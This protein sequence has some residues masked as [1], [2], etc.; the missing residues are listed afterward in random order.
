MNTL[1]TYAR[2]R[3][4]TMPPIKLGL[5]A[6]TFIGTTILSIS[7][8]GLAEV[9]TYQENYR[10][11]V[12][13]RIAISGDTIVSTVLDSAAHVFEQNPDGTWSEQARLHA[14]DSV[15]NDSFGVSVAIDRDTAIIGAYE[16][17]D[18]GPFSGSAYVFRRGADGRWAE[19]VKLRGSD[20]RENFGWSSAID[21]NTLMVLGTDSVYVFE[22][23]RNGVWTQQSRLMPSGG[24]LSLGD[25]VAISGDT[26]VIGADRDNDEGPFAGAAYIF[27]RNA[28]GDWSERSKVVASDGSA[29]D[30]FGRSVAIDGAKV[31]II[32]G[33][34]TYLFERDASGVWSELAK[35][36]SSYGALG[37]QLGETAAISGDVAAMASRFDDADGSAY[38]FDL[39]APWAFEKGSLLCPGDINGDDIAELAVLSRRTGQVEVKD[40]EG[41]WVNGFGVG[42]AVDTELL[43]DTNG[44][45][46]PEVALLLTGPTRGEVR[47]LLNGGVLGTASFR[48]QA[49]TDLETV[50][51]IPGIGGPM[52]IGVSRDPVRAEVWN[53]LSGSLFSIF[54]FSS[55]MTSASLLVYPDSDGDGRPELAVL[56]ENRQAA[57]ADQIEIRDVSGALVRQIWLGKGWRVLGH[58]LLT[59]LNGNGSNE[60]AVLRTHPAGN[61]NVQIRDTTSKAWVGFAGFPVA[62]PPRQLLAVRDINGNGSDELVVFGQHF[63]GSNQRG[64]IKDSRT[65]QRLNQ[66]WFDRQASWR[67]F[68]RCGDING[69]GSDDVAFLGQRP[70]GQY[71]AI[72]KDSETGERLARVLF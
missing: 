63:D 25:A 18:N 27:N 24:N 4:Q 70:S 60:V 20:A 66:L 68:V 43:A 47:D 33:R 26:A 6:R 3:E 50:S 22:A 44:N 58:S 52:L 56:G 67:D 46:A 69:N 48:N 8:Q 7:L 51:G 38:V 65:G 29:D 62:Y 61:V 49:V 11:S 37:R 59:D 41:R 2:G 19:L 1:S 71:L 5:A 53:G 34:S 40:L 55:Y 42:E 14:G 21:D 39:D 13:E 32:G 9:P 15:G 45:G 54:N 10:L 36:Q 28:S 30:R 57:G 64:L 72:V 17:D 31:V 23:D 35:F 16:D 12:G